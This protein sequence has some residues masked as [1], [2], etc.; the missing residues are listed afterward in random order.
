MNNVTPRYKQEFP[1][2]NL[3]VVLPE[4]FEDVSWHNDTCPSFQHNELD[5]IIYIDFA[6]PSKREHEETLRF[7]LITTEDGKL[8]DNREDLA[9]TDDFAEILAKIEERKVARNPAP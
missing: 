6:E 3:D 9:Y 7:S 2:F 5:V 8:T 1:D 4:G